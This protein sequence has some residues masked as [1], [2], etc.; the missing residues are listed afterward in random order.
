MEIQTKFL[1]KVTIDPATIIQFPKGIPAFEEEKE[2]VLIPLA[3]NSPFISLQSIHTAHVGF[4]AAFP[5]DFKA[6][7]AFDLDTT[8]RD[9]LQ[10]EK[11]EDV[12]VYSLLTL[13]D[14]LENSTMNLLAPVI[15]NVVEKKGKQIVLNEN[16]QHPL[17]Y[18]LRSRE[19]SVR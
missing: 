8:D 9:F 18:P 5:Y 16:E 10:I 3:E 4:I 17:R 19:G 7:Y 15:I 2:F 13:K 14:T 12:I 6:D 11:E 1:G